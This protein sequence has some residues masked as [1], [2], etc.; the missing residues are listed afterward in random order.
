MFFGLND[1]ISKGELNTSDIDPAIQLLM[2]LDSEGLLEAYVLLA[3][4]DDEISQDYESYRTENRDA[5]RRYL[6]RYVIHS[7]TSP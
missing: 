5:I 1:Q 6:D 2:N 4:A 7:K 3:L